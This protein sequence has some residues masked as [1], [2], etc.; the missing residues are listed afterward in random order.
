[1]SSPC[2]FLKSCVKFGVPATLTR[3]IGAAESHSAKPF[4]RVVTQPVP[5]RVIELP[6]HPIEPTDGRGYRVQ[7]KPDPNKMCF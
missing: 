5:P 6:S 3:V 2:K 1:M 4:V 7:R